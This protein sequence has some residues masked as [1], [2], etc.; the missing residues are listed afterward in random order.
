MIIVLK[1]DADPKQVESL[2]GWLK[3]RNITPHIS[4]GHHETLIGCV[5]DVAKM[6]V[7]LVQ[8]LS[9]VETV[10]RI[11]EPYKAANRKFHPEPSTIDCSGVKVGGG[12][13]GVI[14]GPCSVESEAQIVALA[15]ELC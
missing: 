8:A 9:V 13:F 3:D 1:K 15:K 2:V 7:G 11:Q 10:Q 12:H 5:G 4:A 6:D 14:A